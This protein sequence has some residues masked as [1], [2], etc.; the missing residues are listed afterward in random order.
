MTP[1]AFTLAGITLC[2]M[3]RLLLWQARSPTKAQTWR[4]A[5]LLA[6]QPLVAALL[7]LTLEPPRS[8]GTA[9]TLVVATADSP[10]LA[11]LAAG[12]ALVALPEAPDLPGAI[13][14]PDLATALRTNPGTAR[15]RI[16]GQGLPPRDQAPTGLPLG[17][18]PSPL[19]RGLV[20]LAP[21]TTVSP[22]AAFHVGGSVHDVPGG[23]ATLFDPAGAAV[24]RAPLS[25]SGDF[26]LSATA[27]AA[28]PAEFSLRITDRNQRLVETATVP[29]VAAE[30]PASRI[31]V[32]AGAAGPDL[33]YLRRWASDAGLDLG[34]SIAAGSGLDIG[35]APPRLD[36]ASLARLDLL[37]LDERSWAAMGAGSR[38]AVLNA[39]RAGLGLV[40]RVTG[41]LPDATR[42]EWTALGFRTDD[43]SAPLRLAP[44][45]P[46]LTR[47]GLAGSNETAPLVK[48]AGGS[49]AGLWRAFGRGRVGLWPVTDL[50]AL[51]LAGNAPRHAAL[52]SDVFA[53]LARPQAQ[54][55]PL[56][57]GAA[58]PSQRLALCNLPAG[59]SIVH[60]DGAT[61]TLVVDGGC[62]AFWPRL[63]GWHELRS[64]A[65]TPFA[66]AAA[67]APRTAAQARTATQ[68]LVT[69]DGIAT[70]APGSRSA[71]WPWFIAWA[72]AAALLWWFERSRL[73]RPGAR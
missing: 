5:V 32:V 8:P 62:A 10:R 26:S 58:A 13:R 72:A 42:R 16:I 34:A 1:L 11:A 17:F 41:P 12:D 27:R 54:S 69:P 38:A 23:S 60:P 47:L 4:I 40:L 19:P 66:V 63:P 64:P 18:D 39:V 24:A 20:A 57:T 30:T 22:G 73:G 15:L 25:A 14:V 9:G 65:S 45:T 52:W 56:I 6:L 59:A 46:A 50:Y 35:D 21:P 44:E 49:A 37:V 67:A 55:T 29:V 71:T 28:G 48:D 31:L 68:A 70:Q 43:A 33:K 7:W 51:V 36:A 2:G 53:T 61:S 3:A